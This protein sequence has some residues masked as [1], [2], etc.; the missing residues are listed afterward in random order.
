M[1]NNLLC[2]ILIFCH[3]TVILP[4]K[5]LIIYLVTNKTADLNDNLFNMV[6]LAKTRCIWNSAWLP[7][8]WFLT[9]ELL[10][11]QSTYILKTPTTKH[12]FELLKELRNAKWVIDGTDNCAFTLSLSHS[13][14]WLLNKMIIFLWEPP[15]VTP[16]IWN[17]SLHDHVALVFTWDDNLIDQKKYFLFRWPTY[18]GFKLNK[19]VPFAERKLCC[20]I[21]ANKTSKHKDSLYQKRLEDALF[22]ESTHPDDF[23]FYGVGWPTNK[24]KTYHGQIPDDAKI[25]YQGKYK[26]CLCYENMQNVQ[27]YVTEKIFNCFEAGCVPIY[28]GV[29][30]ITQFIPQN[31]FIDRRK[32]KNM[33]ELY[34]FLKNIDQEKYAQY[35]HNIRQYLDSNE[36]Y[37]FTIQRFAEYVTN[38]IM[39]LKI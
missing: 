21:N 32:F 25:E 22:F 18:S 27:G 35:L 15:V 30:N 26:F 19:S 17:T 2:L 29:D 6:D 36:T 13:D 11:K 9:N 31:C 28:W 38:G 5:P 23:D 20:L 7:N 33:P 12:K 16:H 24:Y 39:S 3:I 34:Q 4:K 8:M 10:K 14:K 1:K 37:E